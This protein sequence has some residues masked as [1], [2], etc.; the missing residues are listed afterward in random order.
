[1]NAIEQKTVR[2][3]R[4]TR[5]SQ[6]EPPGLDTTL[7]TENLNDEQWFAR[8]GGFIVRDSSADETASYDLDVNPSMAEHLRKNLDNLSQIVPNGHLVDVSRAIRKLPPFPLQD[9]YSV[10]VSISQAL[11]RAAKHDPEL[12]CKAVC[13]YAHGVRVSDRLLVLGAVD[14]AHFGRDLIDLVRLMNHPRIR[15]RIVRFKTDKTIPKYLP[16]EWQVPLGLPSNTPVH[17]I[18]AKNKANASSANQIA[19]Q[20]VERDGEILEAPRSFYSVMLYARIV[21][22]W[23]LVTPWSRTI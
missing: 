19:I 23:R 10:A 15:W 12:V 16:K 7:P 1:M 2:R 21:E 20:V 13:V 9:S 8:Y 14:Q 3:G 5:L 4:R 17:T 6:F 18:A 22:I 11:M